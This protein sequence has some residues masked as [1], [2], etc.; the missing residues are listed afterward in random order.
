MDVVLQRIYHSQRDVIA[1]VIPHI[2]R[3]ESSRVD[4]TYAI[5]FATHEKLAHFIRTNQPTLIKFACSAMLRMWNCFTPARKKYELWTCTWFCNCEFFSRLCNTHCLFLSI[6]LPGLTKQLQKDFHHMKM[7]TFEFT[8]FQYVFLGTV[9]FSFSLSL[10][11]FA[12]Y[13]VG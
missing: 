7:F 2:R 11:S 6:S 9:F 4:S 8:A 13:V 5:T 3:I 12:L 1:S 10:S